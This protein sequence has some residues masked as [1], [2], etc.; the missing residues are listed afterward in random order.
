M[1]MYIVTIKEKENVNKMWQPFLYES[2]KTQNCER[3]EAGCLG[4]GFE[5]LNVSSRKLRKIFHF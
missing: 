2:L 1:R 5:R 3:I 4:G